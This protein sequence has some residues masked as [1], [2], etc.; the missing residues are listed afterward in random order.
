MKRKD[1]LQQILSAGTLVATGPLQSLAGTTHEGAA[2][3]L[4]SRISIDLDRTIP[5]LQADVVVAGAGLG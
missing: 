4:S 1:F 5:I 2:P 3:N